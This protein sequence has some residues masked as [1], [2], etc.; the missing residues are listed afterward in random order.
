MTD[1][2]LLREVERDPYLTR[3][4]AII[5]DE[6][7]ERSVSTDI[8]IGHLS[9]YVSKRNRK[10]PEDKLKLI[11]M[12]AT[13][14]VEDFMPLPTRRVQ[15]FAQA[16]PVISVETRQ[17]D[18]SLH[19]NRK[20]D[21][22]Y[23]SEA[24]TKVTKIHRT[25][26]EGGI[27]VFVSGQDEVEK[28][29]KKLRH[30]FPSKQDVDVEVLKNEEEEEK[31]LDKALKQA[32]KSSKFNVDLDKYQTQPDEDA[33]DGDGDD[34][35]TGIDKLTPPL[36]TLPLFSKLD[37]KEQSKVF[38]K[39]PDGHRLCVI[40]TNVAETSLTIP[41][42]IKTFSAEIAPIPHFICINS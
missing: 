15:L 37:P 4:S 14:R 40:A 21:E 11:V 2:I 36:W 28:L 1:G 19:F 26:P 7:H 3:Y 8:L 12:S 9:R 35:D 41:G 17:F 31:C 25:L 39:P 24:F 13:L 33:L 32:K 5:I 18:V 23:L 20:T 38:D 27:L 30:L 10:H 16:P 29:V 22:D 42:T 6:A 34:V